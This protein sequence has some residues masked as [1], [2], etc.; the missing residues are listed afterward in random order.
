MEDPKKSY[1]DYVEAA[2]H[3]QAVTDAT[4]VAKNVRS[5]AK[6]MEQRVKTDKPKMAM[7]RKMYTIDSK[8]GKHYDEKGNEVDPDTNQPLT[9][10]EKINRHDS[11][12]EW[13]STAAMLEHK[14]E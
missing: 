3:Q 5:V 4:R 9:T 11:T 14:E 12:G 2:K 13:E 8:T 10:S 7:M 6:Q 1:N